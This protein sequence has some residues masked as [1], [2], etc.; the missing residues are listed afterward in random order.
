MPDTP[1]NEREGDIPIRCGLE[2]V[3]LVILEPV[4]LKLSRRIELL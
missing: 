1:I 4:E 2:R 3:V